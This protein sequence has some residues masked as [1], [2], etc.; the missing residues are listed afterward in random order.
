MERFTPANLQ[1]VSG[2]V[3]QDQRQ[4]SPADACQFLE[5]FLEQNQCSFDEDMR[6]G[7]TKLKDA[8]KS[9]YYTLDFAPVVLQEP[10]D[11]L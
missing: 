5:T 9:T 6:H 2:L 11:L 10:N 8:L 3:Q 1:T 7:L 4:I